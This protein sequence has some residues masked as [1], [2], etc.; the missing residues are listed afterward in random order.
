MNIT[1]SEFVKGI[2]GTDPILKE[3]HSQIAFVGR[4]NVGKSSV[5]NSLVMKKDL[6]KSSS[7]PGKTREINFFLINKK[8]YFVDLPGY[9]FARMGAKGAEKIRKL[10]LWYLGSREAVVGFVVLIVDSVVMPMP[11]DK[12]MADILRAENIPFVAVAN[13]IDRLN[14][15]ERSHNIKAIE[16]GLGATVLQYSARTHYGREELL[17]TIARAIK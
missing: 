12:E 10:I 5:I 15:T 1:S 2:I 3:K 9:G 13:K 17:D 16:A 7:M 6:V 14:Q 11:Y 4:S 8:L